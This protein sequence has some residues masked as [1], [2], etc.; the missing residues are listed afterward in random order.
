[1]SAARRFD[2]H[3][4]AGWL[5][6]VVRSAIENGRRVIAVSPEWASAIADELD[7]PD[8]ATGGHGDALAWQD[9]HPAPPPTDRPQLRVI[10]GGQP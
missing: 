8:P 5:R 2:R 9:E 7:P 1:M 3:V 6:A 4:V 10:R